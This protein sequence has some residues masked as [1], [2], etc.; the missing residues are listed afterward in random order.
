MIAVFRK[1]DVAPAAGQNFT[2]LR[3][4]SSGFNFGIDVAGSVITTAGITSTELLGT[5]VVKDCNISVSTEPG[6]IAQP[7]NVRTAQSLTVEDNVLTGD[8]N[9]DH[10]I[11]VI[12]VR[13][14]LIRG[15][16]MRHHG[17]SAIK[18]LTGGF[19][20]DGQAH[21]DTGQGYS[22]WI[23]EDN[24]ITD[25]VFAMAFYTYCESVLP[26]LVIARN[27]I[28]DIP[29]VYEP[30]G[31]S[32]YIAAACASVIEEVT[33][34]GNVFQNLGLGGTFLL[35]TPQPDPCPIAGSRGTIR[36]FSST[37][38]Q[39][40]NWSIAHP[41]SYAAISSSAGTP[42][43]L[44]RATISQMLADGQGHGRIDL[45]LQVFQQ[46]TRRR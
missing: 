21:C 31:A 16:T 22:S 9:D 32:V 11:Y 4:H 40:I 6:A 8:D 39:Y 23:I 3:F 27:R 45:N 43:H 30:D 7:V 28:R 5:V 19:G 44:I 15:N 41:G 1:D 13:K 46:V 24:V 37:A 18:L 33:M 17:N 12:A 26:S 29:Q 2:F 36:D 42:G 25:S 38:D 14:V 34:T 10:A 20:S 35:S